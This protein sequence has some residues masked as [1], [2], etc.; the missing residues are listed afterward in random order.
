MQQQTD[1]KGECLKRLTE[2]LAEW[3]SADVRILPG[4]MGQLRCRSVESDG[5]FEYRFHWFT[6]CQETYIHNHGNSFETLCLEGEYEEKQWQIVNDGQGGT[7]F[8]FL[9]H[10]GN[11][12]DSPTEEPG[13]LQHVVT[14][15]HPPGNQMRL[16]TH[17]YHSIWRVGDAATRVLTFVRREKCEGKMRYVLSPS[18]VID[19]PTEELRPATEEE[20]QQ[21]REKLE[22][23][24]LR[25]SE[26]SN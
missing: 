9:R 23:L 16:D 2:E 11:K 21:M 4:V 12:F 22:E 26:Q 18:A 15:R 3:S 5:E 6:D 8:Q 14:R 20:R 24:R 25:L 17:Q 13:R 19:A 7:V 10:Q 1:M